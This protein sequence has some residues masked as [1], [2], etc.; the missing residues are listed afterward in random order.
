M[1]PGGDLDSEGETECYHGWGKKR[2]GPKRKK[3]EQSF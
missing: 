1:I 2:V 3:P